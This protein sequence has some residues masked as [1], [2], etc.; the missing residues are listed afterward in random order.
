MEQMCPSVDTSWAPE[1]PALE[2]RGAK[3]PAHYCLHVAPGQGGCN[4]TGQQTGRVNV[5]PVCF[6]S[7]VPFLHLDPGATRVALGLSQG[8]YPR[9]HSSAC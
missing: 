8:R 2:D 1:G 6:P 7:C 3:N 5:L 4:S 9:R